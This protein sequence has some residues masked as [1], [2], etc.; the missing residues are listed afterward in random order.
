MPGKASEVNLHIQVWT[1]VRLAMKLSHTK[2]CGIPTSSTFHKDH[3]KIPNVKESTA[4]DGLLHASWLNQQG[5][6]NDA[7]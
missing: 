3:K 1:H 5:P 4:I 7:V 2:H 6:S